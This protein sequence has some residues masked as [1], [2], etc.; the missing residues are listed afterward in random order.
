MR[1]AAREL[2]ESANANEWQR[3]IRQ[4]AL[5]TVVKFLIHPLLLPSSRTPLS[6]SL[7]SL[8]FHI[9]ISI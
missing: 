9:L 5:V 4:H 6:S 2:A 1:R 7:S 8:K 3:Q